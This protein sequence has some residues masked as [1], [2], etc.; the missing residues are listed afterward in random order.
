M[1][2]MEDA[3]N[4]DVILALDVKTFI[5][6]VMDERGLKNEQRFSSLE[7]SISDA[8]LSIKDALAA[9]L[10]NTKA[11]LARATENTKD[12]LVT[13]NLRIG[14]VVND[15][16]EKHHS[17]DLAL[18]TAIAA[19]EKRLEGMNEFRNSLRDQAAGFLTRNEYL[20]AHDAVVRATDRTRLELSR[21]AV[22]VDEFDKTGGIERASLE[23]RLDQMNEFRA[24]MKDQTASFVTRIKSDVQIKA[25][26]ADLHRV[27]LASSA[28]VD[29]ED[30][31]KLEVRTKEAE[32]KL[33]TWDG[34]LWAL[35]SIFLF[36]NI[37]VSW[38]LSGIHLGSHL[39]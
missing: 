22:R 34:R 19:V 2:S 35:G 4:S 26:S 32:N 17:R 25:M 24:Q 7:K 18:T 36:L 15:Q 8:N 29:K 9:A 20:A 23:K 27:E 38:F 6:A 10:D 37:L 14:T 33:A 31:E 11:A 13:A 5:M 21:Y 30:F 16:N 39:Q 12:A 3:K 1:V 28:L